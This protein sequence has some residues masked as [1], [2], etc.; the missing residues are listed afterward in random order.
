MLI[1]RRVFAFVGEKDVAGMGILALIGIG[2]KMILK[3]S[4]D[5]GD[6]PRRGIGKRAW[7][8]QII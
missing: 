8:L 1:L 3:K 7:V 5:A 2:L 6:H 4:R